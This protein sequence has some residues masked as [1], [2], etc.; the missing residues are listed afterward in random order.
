V[1]KAQKGL[2]SVVVKVSIYLTGL[3]KETDPKYMLSQCLFLLSLA[4]NSSKYLEVFFGRPDLEAVI[5]KT[6]PGNFVDLV[7]LFAVVLAIF[8]SYSCFYIYPSQ[9]NSSYPIVSHTIP[10]HYNP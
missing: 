5:L 2:K 1:V 4:E 6:C 10:S 3:G 9:P 8:P 7:L